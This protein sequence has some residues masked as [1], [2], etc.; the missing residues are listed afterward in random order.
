MNF[1]PIA[2]VFIFIIP[3]ILIVGLIK[4]I[5]K[6]SD[7]Y[8]YILLSS[9][10]VLF[11]ILLYLGLYSWKVGQ[12]AFD[13]IWNFFRQAFVHGPVN[14]N[15]MLAIYHQ[16]G[17]FEN[18]TTAEQL[19]DFL[20]GQMRM[21]VP[22]AILLFSLIYGVFLFLIIRLIISKLA[23]PVPAVPAFENWTLPRRISLGLILLLLGFFLVNA[24]GIANVE[25]AQYTI[26][27][28]ISF[29]FSIIGLSVVWFFLKAGRVPSPLRWLLAIIVYLILGFVLPI[30]GIVDQFIHLR[31]RYKNRF[32]TTNGG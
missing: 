24:L 19:A 14:G 3:I 7:F 6:K 13:T 23:S 8:E 27:V 16:W 17:V 4:R 29:L 18:F 1:L 21:N 2:A 11:S 30:L 26:T 12:S 31:I 25:V 22:A 5:G 10:S 9:G 32:R 15:Q 20:I 28:L